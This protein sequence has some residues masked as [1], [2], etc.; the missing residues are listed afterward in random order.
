METRLYVS[1]YQTVQVAKSKIDDRLDRTGKS[2]LDSEA[3]LFAR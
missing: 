1:G 2:N 3:P